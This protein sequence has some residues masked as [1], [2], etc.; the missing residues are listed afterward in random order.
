MRTMLSL[1]VLMLL[2][3]GSLAQIDTESNVMTML[4]SLNSTPYDWDCTYRE[5]NQTVTFTLYLHRPVNTDFGTGEERAVTNVAGFDCRVTGSEGVNIL[6]WDFPVPAFDFGEGDDL[7]VLYSEPVPVTGEYV[8]LA[9]CQVY[10]GDITSFEL[11]EAAVPRCTNHAN[12]WIDVEPNTVPAIA[13]VVSYTDADDPYDPQVPGW[14][15]SPG[16]DTQFEIYMDQ[17]VPAE[18]RS[19]GTLK[20]LYD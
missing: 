15:R 18:S 12:A 9:T 4:Q 11:P 2:A 14:C 8:V 13:G 7:D 19:W 10:F 16:H 3:T 20:A 6:S 1:F 17:T 5:E